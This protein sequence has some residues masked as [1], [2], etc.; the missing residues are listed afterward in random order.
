ML[1]DIKDGQRP[2]VSWVYV[3]G[4]GSFLLVAVKC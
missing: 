2:E 1:D 3:S 4:V